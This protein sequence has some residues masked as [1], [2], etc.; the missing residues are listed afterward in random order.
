MLKKVFLLPILLLLSLGASCPPKPP[1]PTPTPT[2]VPTPT[3]EPVADSRP[4]V[5]IRL[6]LLLRNDGTGKLLRGNQ[7]FTLN[8]VIPC[9]SSTENRLF[10]EGGVEI[11][12]LWP[13]ASYEWMQYTKT[14]G[15]NAVHF[16]P[17]F[18]ETCCGWES[19]GGPYLPDGT[20]NPNFW[21]KFHNLHFQAGALGF[22]VEEDTLDTWV[23]KHGRPPFE[24]VQTPFSKSELAHAFDVPLSP[25]VVKWVNKIVYETCNYGNVIYQIGN[26]SEQA[27]GWTKEWERAMH[28][29]IREAELQ[30]GCGNQPGYPNGIT[31]MIGS[32]TRDYD[33]PY[34]YFQ[35][36]DPISITG[37]I[38]SRPYMVN[39][40]NPHLSPSQF[41]TLHCSAKKV[42]QSF[43]YWRSDGSDQDQTDSL[44]MINSCDV[45][46]SCPVPQPDKNK[47]T[48]N[49]PCTNNGI[50]D[51]T[52]IVTNSC[53][54]C[55]S[56]GMGSINGVPR[57]SCPI[58]NE[59]PD[60]PGY[61]GMCQ[62]R[63]PCEQY[64][65]ERNTP[66]WKSDGEIILVDE[67]GFRARCNGCTYLEACDN[68]A[69]HCKRVV[70]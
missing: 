56:I 6:E 47:L 21:K 33:G 62:D 65:M 41:K 42:G 3:P 35:D 64:V 68:S 50:C 2:P 61:E 5:P 12:Y 30:P 37:P 34:D 69:S 40:Y 60:T 18:S 53:E 38:G 70:F 23:I 27:P 8:G 10:I 29:Q 28:A 36:H 51:A 31:H 54:Y 22:T 14:K 59:C 13:L 20:W 45:I 49:L 7:P 43:W 48:F 39:E 24:D 58:R 63:L 52:P 16:R 19:I 9:W 25:A 26:E 1:T 11:P 57:C 32:N 15:G 44:N 46:S 17:F 4:I 67:Y 66:L 55:A